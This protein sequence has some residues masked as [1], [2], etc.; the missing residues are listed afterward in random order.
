[1]CP[2]AMIA[3]KA[4]DANAFLQLVRRC[5]AEVVIPS[6][7]IHRIR[8]RYSK[9]NCQGGAIDINIALG[10]IDYRTHR[11]PRGQVEEVTKDESIREKLQPWTRR[12][13]TSVGK[14]PTADGESHSPLAEKLL[15]ALRHSGDDD[16]ILTLGELT[17]YVE[18]LKPRPP[19][20]QL[21]EKQP[22]SDF[23][24]IQ[25]SQ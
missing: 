20:G 4:Y 8:R 10:G 11:L 7:K 9:L 21:S 22:E 1:V 18:K 14:E 13:L 3:D 23:L 25:R 6:L 2:N 12:F 5:K 16:G 19:T 24:F 15:D 17:T